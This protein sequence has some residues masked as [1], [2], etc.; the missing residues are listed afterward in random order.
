MNK[1][2]RVFKKFILLKE[3]LKKILNQ[4]NFKKFKKILHN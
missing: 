4:L 3:N 2:L 1:M